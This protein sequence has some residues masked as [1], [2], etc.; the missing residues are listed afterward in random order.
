MAG[1]KIQPVEVDKYGNIDTAHLKAM[2][3][4]FHLTD[5]SGLG[6]EEVVGVRGWMVYIS[7]SFFCILIK[8]LQFLL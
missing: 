5:G 4:I 7:I 2:V 3:P 1:M 8:R 6:W